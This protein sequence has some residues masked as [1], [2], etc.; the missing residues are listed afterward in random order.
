MSWRGAAAW[1]A[2]FAAL[3]AIANILLAEDLKPK[4]GPIVATPE[5]AQ[6]RPRSARVMRVVDGDTIVVRDSAGGRTERVRYIG[7]DT[8]ETVK[9][10]TP[11]Q[12]F[13]REASEFNHRLVEGKTVRLVPDQEPR[14]RYGRSL[15][16]VYVG[17][18]FVNAELI[19]GGFARTI[20]IEPN[21]GK[22]DYFADL[23]RVAIR[24][25]KGLWK[26]CAR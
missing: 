15:A 26:A 17:G 7:V 10:D 5:A 16:Y 23:E 22:A 4:D 11:V 20:E 14:D 6:T 21:T 18:T 9:E 12:C 13:G 8:P 25:N 3:V 19:R 2:A 24:T 1:V